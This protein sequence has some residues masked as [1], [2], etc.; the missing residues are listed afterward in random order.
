MQENT[1]GSLPPSHENWGMSVWDARPGISAIKITTA[2]SEKPEGVCPKVKGKEH[3]R[4]PP[5]L[6]STARAG[7]GL[8]VCPHPPYAGARSPK[9]MVARARAW[10]RELGLGEV[11]RVEPPLMEV[12]SL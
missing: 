5:K 8:S 11:T 2:A 6:S 12:V 1:R 7:Y 9:V 3:V 10:G 4:S